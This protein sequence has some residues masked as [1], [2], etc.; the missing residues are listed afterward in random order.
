[1]KKTEVIKTTTERQIR[2]NFWYTSLGNTNK[3]QS[4]LT[5]TS[6]SE[7]SLERTEAIVVNTDTRRVTTDIKKTIK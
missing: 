4:S 2:K 7:N 6:P 5:A 1:M 3:K